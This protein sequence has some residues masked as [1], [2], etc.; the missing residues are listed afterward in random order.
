MKKIL[1]TLIAL[2]IANMALFIGIGTIFL[3][4]IALQDSPIDPL[5]P[6]IMLGIFI[7][8]LSISVLFF[9]LA[10]IRGILG[11]QSIAGYFLFILG[12]IILGGVLIFMRGAIPTYFENQKRM[13]QTRSLE[14]FY[15]NLPNLVTVG[16][17]VYIAR[18]ETENVPRGSTE[19][20]F[21]IQIPVTFNTTIKRDQILNAF[22]MVWWAVMIG[23]LS[24]LIMDSLTTEGV[25]WFFP[26]P[27]RLG[28][29]P[30]KIMRIKTGGLLEKI[31]VFPGL[32]LIN[33]YLIYINYYLYLNF[34]RHL[35]K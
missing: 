9:S 1:F 22:N 23:Y 16:Q 19:Y 35:I 4:P 11:K 15:N 13:E 29:P 10:I 31:L 18:R 33:S 20:R 14:D 26:I 17:P 7:V 3:F 27:V 8:V 32:L 2:A 28:F 5:I 34:F 24:H 6:D 30:I 21:E 12:G 25:P